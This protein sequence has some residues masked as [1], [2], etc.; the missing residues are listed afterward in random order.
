MVHKK[1]NTPSKNVNNDSSYICRQCEDNKND[2][3]DNIWHQFTFANDYFAKA[4]PLETRSNSDLDTS[5][6]TDNWKVF[7]KG[8]RH[9]IHVNIDSVL[10]KTDELRVIA[11]KSMAGLIGMTESKLDKTVLDEE[12]NT[13][14]FEPA[15]SHQN[16]HF[17]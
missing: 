15:R 10:S 11:K 2:P 17:L 8:G 7:N 16:R 4:V 9:L 1:C 3:S 6:F 14:G 12:I 5:S 13:D